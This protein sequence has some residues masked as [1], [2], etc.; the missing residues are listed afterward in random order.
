MLYFKD[1]VYD[2][3]GNRKYEIVEYE[4]QQNQVYTY[5]QV[6]QLLDR[7]GY[8]SVYG[9]VY[10]GSKIIF[11]RSTPA[12]M[13]ID[14]APQGSTFR[15]IVDNKV[16]TYTKVGDLLSSLGWYWKAL[17]PMDGESGKLTRDYLMDHP[18]AIVQFI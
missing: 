11:K 4:T 14:M 15:L 17:Q 13:M 2:N 10:T 12:I 1:F 5:E 3:R 7:I 6:H 8:T 16:K 18:N 9:V